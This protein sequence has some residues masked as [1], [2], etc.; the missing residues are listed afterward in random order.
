[1]GSPMHLYLIAGWNPILKLP[2]KTTY[3]QP[4]HDSAESVEKRSC[5]LGGI[6]QIG[7]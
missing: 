7:S 3:G 1:M 5:L 6:A 2:S 4:P